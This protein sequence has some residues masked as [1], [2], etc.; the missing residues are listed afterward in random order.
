MSNLYETYTVT[1]GKNSSKQI[2]VRG[3]S[4]FDIT[5]LIRV[6]KDDIDRALS[7]LKDSEDD[8]ASIVMNFPELALELF[9][10][11]VEGDH[12]KDELKHLP[13]PIQLECLE[14]IYLMT[15]EDAGGL[16]SFLAMIGRYTSGT[17]Q[18]THY[19]NSLKKM[20]QTDTG[21]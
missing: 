4:V 19:L 7:V 20:N 11:C 9:C 6:H 15:I 14:Q 3:L 12:T 2:T 8:I 1:F 5:K 17:K 16:H 10:Q 18:L 13:F 21:T